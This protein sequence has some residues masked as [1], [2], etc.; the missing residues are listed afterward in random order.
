MNSIMLTGVSLSLCIKDVCEA[1]V[2][3]EQVGQIIAATR[4]ANDADF[5]SVVGS[6]KRTYWR[7]HPDE[8]ERYARSL[9]TAGKIAQPL[10]CNERHPGFNW[11]Y[12]AHGAPSSGW[13]VG[14]VIAAPV[15]D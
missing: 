15:T 5:E 2:R 10:L 7:K 11:D 12:E 4:M 14:E 3:F 13:C 1:K 6:Y 9:W 8:A